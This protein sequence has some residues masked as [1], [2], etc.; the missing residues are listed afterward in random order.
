MH[1]ATPQE[2]DRAAAIATALH[3]R[4]NRLMDKRVGAGK[5]ADPTSETNP[6]PEES[7]LMQAESNVLGWLYVAKEG[8]HLRCSLE[9]NL[10]EMARRLKDWG[11]PVPR[12][13]E[14]EYRNDQ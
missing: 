1:I 11:L 10:R 6:A 2:I 8:K 5:W 9:A 14:S 4:L 3:A 13:V 12:E 7:A